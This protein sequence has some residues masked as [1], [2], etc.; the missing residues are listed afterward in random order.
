MLSY[1]PSRA[2]L[3]VRAVFP[4]PNQ[5]QRNGFTRSEGAVVSLAKRRSD[6]R[7]EQRNGT[8]LKAAGWCFRTARSTESGSVPK[9]RVEACPLGS[10]GSA[11]LKVFN[12]HCEKHK[13]PFAHPPSCLLPAAPIHVAAHLPT[14]RRF[15]EKAR[16]R[17]DLV[18]GSSLLRTDCAAWFWWF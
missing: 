4:E 6:A 9:F 3:C 14:T 18:A 5:Q 12:E 13:F 8:I 15:H 1:C 16:L 10:A 17:H 7:A 2:N 11:E